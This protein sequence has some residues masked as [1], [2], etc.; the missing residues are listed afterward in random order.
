MEGKNDFSL[1]FVFVT[2]E[3]EHDR[4]ADEADGSQSAIHHAAITGKS[5][6]ASIPFSFSNSIKVADLHLSYIIG[7]QIALC[8]AIIS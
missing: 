5:F 1:L 2:G 3:P 8:M 7:Q 4:T 6:H